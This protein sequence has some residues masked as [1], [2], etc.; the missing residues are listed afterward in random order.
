[1][2]RPTRRQRPHR[3]ILAVVALIVSCTAEATSQSSTFEPSAEWPF[4][5]GERAV[6]DVTFGPIRVGEGLLLVETTETLAGVTSYRVAFEIAG[7][8]FFYKIDDRSV[9]WVATDPFRSMRFEQI[10]SEGSY[11]R[12][13]RYTFDH[14]ALT[15]SRE[16]WDAEASEY[17]PHVEEQGIGIPPAAL[18]EIAYLF[19]ARML[20]LQVGRTYEFD[21]YFEEEGNPVILEVLRRERVRVSAGRFNTVVVHPVIQTEGMFGEGGEA[22]LYITDDDRRVIVQIK[23][24]MR[25]GELNMY[26]REYDAGGG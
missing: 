16:D 17:R 26:L 12:H 11:R 8:P 22:E 15:Y 20:P 1:M 25:V 18:D 14:E 2:T 9:S 4:P 5:I 19:L 3:R 23:T 10:L 21:R 13:R 6:Y 7:G 24:R